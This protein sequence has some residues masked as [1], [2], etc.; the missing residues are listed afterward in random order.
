MPP[1]DENATI[2]RLDR[3]FARWARALTHDEV[4]ALRLYQRTDRPYEEINALL[5]GDTDIGLLPSGRLREILTTIENLD[6]AIAKGP[7][8][9]PLRA[10]RGLR[11]V[12]R[13]FGGAA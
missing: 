1:G 9:S 2:A 13:V 7:I 4:A 3:D 5:R 6:S 11:S 8:T 10:L 12:E